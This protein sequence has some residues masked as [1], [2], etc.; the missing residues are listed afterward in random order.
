[1]LRWQMECQ[2][3][4][5]PP[6]KRHDTAAAARGAR[7]EV[8][9]LL[10]S[11]M[12]SSRPPSPLLTVIF[13]PV[14]PSSLLGTTRAR[15]WTRQP[16][17]LPEQQPL[18]QHQ[19][20][21]QRHQLQQQPPHRPAA[22][23]LQPNKL[24]LSRFPSSGSRHTGQSLHWCL[25]LNPSTSLSYQTQSN[26]TPPSCNTACSIPLAASNSVIPCPTE[27]P[28]NKYCHSHAQQQQQW[29]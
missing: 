4:T 12:H 5:G 7:E 15:G 26:S 16:H 17:L 13:K 24:S 23:H 9:S 11:T 2:H 19:P 1:M 6:L 27:P 8:Q 29:Q 22:S 25:A 10:Q 18:Q 20:K 14:K 28:K 3:N 21:W